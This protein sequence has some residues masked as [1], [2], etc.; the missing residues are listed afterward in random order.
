MTR[1]SYETW[2]PSNSCC[3]VF[4]ESYELTPI[5]QRLEDLIDLLFVDK[6]TA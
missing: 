2:L 1:V 3:G 4:D 6:G 5:G